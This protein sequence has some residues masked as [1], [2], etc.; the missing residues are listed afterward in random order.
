MAHLNG[1]F[2]GVDADLNMN[3]TRQKPTDSVMPSASKNRLRQKMSEVISLRERVA[4]AELASHKLGVGDQKTSN[5]RHR[6][7][8][9]H[10]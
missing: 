9:Y 10:R 1:A 7:M 3:R 4:Q 2:N 6:Q 8:M 5:E